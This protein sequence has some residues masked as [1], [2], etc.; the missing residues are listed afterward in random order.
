[1]AEEGLERSAFSLRKN[2][3]DAD[4]AAKSAALV[5]LSPELDVKIKAWLELCPIE[6]TEQQVVDLLKSLELKF[7]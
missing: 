7:T 1:M 3:F 5:R 6:L 2:A 4:C